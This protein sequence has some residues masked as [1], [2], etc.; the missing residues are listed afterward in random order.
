MV[1]LASEEDLLGRRIVV[2]LVHCSGPECRI[3]VIIDVHTN[4]FT[5]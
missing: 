4:P 2:V 3:P 1:S 5:D